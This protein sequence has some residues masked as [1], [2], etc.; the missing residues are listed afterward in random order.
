[1][2]KLN[3]L[4]SAALIAILLIHVVFGSF[5]ILGIGHNGAKILALIGA[6]LLI[7]HILLSGVATT[8]TIRRM[9]S[10]HMPLYVRANR[11]FLLRR[12]SGLGIVIF[13][14]FHIGMFGTM[15]DTHYVLYEFTTTKLLL[16][17]GFMTSLFVHIGTN[18]RPLFVSLGWQQITNHCRDVYVVLGVLYMFTLT[19]ISM[20]YGG[21]QTL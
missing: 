1:M 17:F 19:A 6:G 20:Y 5:M 2:R 18:I 7:L 21:W 13:L 9:V 15:V 3:T 12:L 16:Q 8:Q 10:R 11:L 14:V 4:L